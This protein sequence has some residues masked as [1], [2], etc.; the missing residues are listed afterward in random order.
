MDNEIITELLENNKAWWIKFNSDS[1]KILQISLNDIVNS[2]EDNIVFKTT[3]PICE[4]ILAKRISVR[5]CAIYWDSETDAWDISE[6]SDKLILEYS[7]TKNFQKIEEGTYPVDNDLF[8]TVFKES[9]ELEIS[10]D[11]KN[12]KKSMN[13]A[14]I[15][16]V[17][18]RND[19]SLNLYI[20]K[21]N[22]PDYLITCV[23][24]DPFLLLTKR[25]V[26]ISMEEITK[27][28]D[29][30]KISIYTR[31]IFKK[32]G[33]TFEEKRIVD[34]KEID[35]K[36]V[37]QQCTKDD[38]AHVF[39]YKKDN[40][41]VI[42]NTITESQ[43]YLLQ[44]Q[45]DFPFIVCDGSVDRVCGGWRIS[46]QNFKESKKFVIPIG[47]KWPDRPIILYKNKFIKVK[48][49]GEQHA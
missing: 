14:E 37:I 43:H 39:V 38:N 8:I 2:E 9:N 42:D 24:V 46:L 41:I 27:H 7:S 10:V 29:W 20:T 16:G 6:K 19:E 11:L 34:V 5:R 33:L 21:R 12:I 18:A 28:T 40:N 31:P 32:Y 15:S 3:N 26:S 35:Y 25:R 30:D 23:N 22:D 13:L 44:G 4:E 17:K 1:G 36:H 49:L 45:R 47:Y 48:Y